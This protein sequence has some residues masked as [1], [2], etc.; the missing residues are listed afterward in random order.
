MLDAPAERRALADS[1]PDDLPGQSNCGAADACSAS[2]PDPGSALAGPRFLPSGTASNIVA[3]AGALQS[4]AR[5]SS[6]AAA[7]QQQQGGKGGGS[8]SGRSP[9]NE[10]V[11]GAMMLAYE[12]AGQVDKVPTSA[13]QCLSR[14]E[15]RAVLEEQLRASQ[16]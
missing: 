5:G 3:A 8:R 1:L 11:V 13:F 16:L 9:L 7:E 2:F 12:R 4:T 6:N 10:V 14:T 15:T